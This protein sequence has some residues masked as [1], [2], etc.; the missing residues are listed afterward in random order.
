MISDEKEAEEAQNYIQSFLKEYNIEN[1]K[2][3]D[4]IG[5]VYY[6]LILFRCKLI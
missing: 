2:V 3:T 6:Y 4:K 5:K 1:S